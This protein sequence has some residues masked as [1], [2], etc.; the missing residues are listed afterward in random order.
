MLWYGEENRSV[1]RKSQSA[2]PRGNAV[3]VSAERHLSDPSQLEH[4]PAIKYFCGE[5][6]K[7]LLPFLF[8]ILYSCVA[9]QPKPPRHPN[10][11]RDHGDNADVTCDTTCAILASAG[12]AVLPQGL[13]L[14]LGRVRSRSAAQRDRPESVR[15]RTPAITGASM[16]SATR[17]RA[18]AFGHH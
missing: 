11:L 2:Q 5:F 15:G 13:V 9:L 10:C 3:A 14:G 12:A 18:T 1:R 6:M 17:S 16:P 4:S 8:L 7:R